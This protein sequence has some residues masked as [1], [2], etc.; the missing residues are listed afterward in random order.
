MH[1]LVRHKPSNI[2]IS[3]GPSHSVVQAILSIM[4]WWWSLL[5]CPQTTHNNMAWRFSYLHLGSISISLPELWVRVHAGTGY[6]T[7]VAV[8]RSQ[9]P[10]PDVKLWITTFVDVWILCEVH[11]KGKAFKEL[12]YFISISP[13]LTKACQVFHENLI[14]ASIVL[15]ALLCPCHR[16]TPG[17]L[18]CIYQIK[19]E[20]MSIS[21]INAT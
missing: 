16:T 18:H 5:K 2:R 17:K 14:G 15:V 12:K 1:N 8:A 6:H 9:L 10:L 21:C 11:L 4:W 20:Q 3:G 7:R 19:E 13:R